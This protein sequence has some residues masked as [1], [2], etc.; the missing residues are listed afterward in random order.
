MTIEAGQQCSTTGTASGP[1]VPMP[2]IT[3]SGGTAVNLSA[4][5]GL[6]PNN[7]FRTGEPVFLHVT[8]LDQNLDPAVVESVNLRIFVPAT[9]DVESLI[10]METGTDTG[11]FLG[12]I[13]L[14]SPPPVGGDCTLTT[15][16]DQ[17][18][19]ATYFDASDPSDS[20]MSTALV[21]PYGE[22]FD[23]STGDPIDGAEVTIINTST[24]LPA[25]VYGNDGVSSYPAT[26]TSGGSA[27]DSGG[28]VYDFPPGQYRFPYLLPGN[29]RLQVVPPG[30]YRAP[31][32][33]PTTQLQSLPG[34]PYAIVPGSRSENFNL[35]TGPAMRVDLPLDPTLEG[36]F[37][38]KSASKTEVEVGEF[39]Q[40]RVQVDNEAESAH[41]SNVTLVDTLPVGFRFEPDSA[42][43][44]DGTPIAPSISEDGREL[45]FSLG[46][47]APGSDI[48]VQYVTGVIPIAKPGDAVNT[49]LARAASGAVSN[50]A[51]ALVRVREDGLAEHVVI[52]GRVMIDS[53]EDA[54]NAPHL[55]VPDI[56]LYMED[57]TYVV[58]DENGLFHF[59][60]VR[61]GTHLVQMDEETLPEGYEAVTCN[62]ESVFADQPLSQFVDA[63]RGAIWRTDFRLQRKQSELTQRLRTSRT[64]DGL[65]HR[66]KL[67][68]GSIPV[69]KPNLIVSLPKG[70][71]LLADSLRLDDEPIEAKDNDGTLVIR[72][73]ALEANTSYTLTFTTQEGTHPSEEPGVVTR[74]VLMAKGPGGENLRTP[75]AETVLGNNGSHERVRSE[76]QSVAVLAKAL[77]APAPAA[78]ESAQ[79][80]PDRPEDQ[81]NGNWLA[82]QEVDRAWVYPS[83]D[84]IPKISAVK[85][86]IL[87]P[88]TE[89][90]QL[91]LNGVPV[92]PLSFDGTEK[93]EAEHVAITRWRGVHILDGPNQLVATF[94]DENGNET[95]R[96]ERTVVFTGTPASAE[97]VEAES[98]LVAD[99][100]SVPV[101]AVRLR[102]KSGKLVREGVSGS[103]HVAP[104]HQSLEVME[105]L[106]NPSLEKLEE[107]PA[108]YVVGKDGIAHIELHPTSVVGKAKI[109][110]RFANDIDEEVEAWLSPGDRD[111]ILVALANT[112]ISGN[113]LSGDEAHLDAAGLEDDTFQEGRIAFFAKGR[114]KGDFLLTL[115]YDSEKEESE[116]G[117]RLGQVIDPDEYFTLY[118]DNT[119]QGY[120]AAS[121]DKL[122]VKLEREKFFA[123]Y[124]D[125]S[126]GL[127][128][129]ELGLY[130]RT[131]TGFKTE[132]YGDKLRVSGFAS[133]TDQVF[134]LDEIRGDGTS[135]LYHLSRSPVIIGSDDIKIQVR[136]RY[137]SEV[138]LKEEALTPHVDYDIDY[139]KGTLFFRRPVPSRDE[140]FNPVYIVAR[141][142]IESE[143]YEDITAGGRAAVRML[144]GAVEIG[145]TLIHEEEGQA[146][147]NLVGIDA[148]VHFDE[149]TSLRVEVAGSQREVYGDE[150]QD[151]AMIVQLEHLS[152]DTVSELYYREEGAD[153]GLGQQNRSEPGTRKYGV[154]VRH[155]ITDEVMFD[156]E[157]IHSTNLETEAERKIAALGTEFQRG[158]FAANLG[159]RYVDSEGITNPQLLGGARYGF[160]DG[161]LGVFANGEVGIGDEDPFGDY[162]D[163]LTA[164]A[165]FKIHQNVTLF[166]NQEFSFGE[167]K[168][169]SNTRVGID[170]QPWSGANLHTSVTEE[171]RE[172][173]G[174]TFANL[175]LT[176]SFH[177]NE[178]WSFDAS[179]DRA[180]ALRDGGYPPFNPDVPPVSG[181][182]TEDFTA[183]SLGANFHKGAFSFASR[184]ENRMAETEDRWGLFLS[185][186]RDQNQSTSYSGRLE[187]FTSDL[188]SGQQDTD[189]NLRFSIA[190][191]PLDTKWILLNRLDLDYHES[192]GAGADIETRKL[193]N[194]LK[195]NHHPNR[196]TQFSWH[197][198]VKYI[199]DSIG[200][201]SY[202]SF[203]G[204]VGVEARYHFLPKWDISGHAQAHHTLHSNAYETSYGIALGRSLLK[205]LWISAGYNFDGYTDDDFAGSEY[206]AEGPFLRIRAKLDQGTVR[207]A[208][209]TFGR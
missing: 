177:L 148:E 71:S 34:A 174:R 204:L 7:L 170:A 29:Y 153:F 181:E 53:C 161:R 195:A 155:A 183:I 5:V 61:P 33:V 23:S 169:T 26:V 86:G 9:G 114:V 190:H 208:L 165:D 201:D 77:E 102:D 41:A 10:L 64:R 157:L 135:G 175:G 188:I 31:S 192:T 78:E 8:D 11:T 15:D 180:Q 138:I 4:P 182:R 100:R 186:L 166:A 142:E 14:A 88:P 79:A 87:H 111:W 127:D 196:K 85:I 28:G 12:P 70:S 112:T 30:G 156:L 76:E 119:Q 68:V 105:R 65:E 109:G 110:F 121:S 149:E 18:I 44:G 81:F 123:L 101:L 59:E 141:Y 171:A 202:D 21:D 199:V 147:G 187:F 132:Y 95:G 39:V 6:L 62:D 52:V 179:V 160:F 207:R 137:R 3:S 136:D 118:G 205:A 172:N 20:S 37:V 124:G 108:N 16:E 143:D 150:Q 197:L 38:Q 54:I 106:R 25:T 159:G 17:E 55:G 72:L 125:F 48:S 184:I 63:Q 133:E 173:G 144:D 51:E 80:K 189:A 90:V 42:R 43:L 167:E 128:Q 40:Y 56:R 162:V 209:E 198:G 91:V 151:G 126:T 27:T 74:S 113:D 35:P 49:A 176:Q 115:A 203:T 139:R 84:F 200:G 130:Q 164:G 103:F 145:A 104:P 129:T 94:V 47:M 122:Y 58:T 89:K 98:I 117:R 146:D 116:V 19:L 154:D 46:D 50:L 75:M 1:F 57:G 107:E 178:F 168:D 32:T 158:N 99:G 191:R 2:P 60:G 97:L 73:P 93:D 140:S 82:K 134:T 69:T 36:L 22:V 120:D 83:E 92:S 67:R 152:E 66:V 193:V 206:T 96:I 45:T 24:G 163:R 185:A 131:L 13:M 194:H